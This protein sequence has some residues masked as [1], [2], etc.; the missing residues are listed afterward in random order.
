[1][2][3]LLLSSAYNGLTQ[4]VQPELLPRK[5]TVSVEIA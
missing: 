4:R 1:M 3:I 5:H 2:K